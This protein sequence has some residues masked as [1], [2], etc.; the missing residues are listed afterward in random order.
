MKEILGIFKRDIRKILKSKM[1][2]VILVGMMII[3]GIYAWLN[4]DSN[5]DPYDNTGN[6]EI[7]VV[8]KDEGAEILSSKVN[9][10]E[11]L[12][13]NLKNNDAMKWVFTDEETAKNGVES[14]EYYGAIILPND[15]SGRLTTLLDETEIKKLEF[16]FLVN[17]KKNPIAPIIVNKAVGAVETTLDQAF[18]NK[19]VYNV[20]DKAEDLK[21]DERGTKTINAVTTKLAETKENIGKLKTTINVVADSANATAKAFSAVKDLLPSVKQF[22]DTT[23]T[24]ITELQSDI[25][26]LD[27]VFDEVNDDISNTF[28]VSER[29]S[30]NIRNRL[31]SLSG[32]GLDAQQKLADLDSSLEN[33][34]TI[35]DQQQRIVAALK[36]ITSF[37]ELDKL[38]N[39]I[40]IAK[41]KV[42]VLR[43]DIQGVMD[44]T[45]LIE[46]AKADANELA[47]S[48]AS[49]ASHY[50]DSI[51][52][53]VKNSFSRLNSS[54]KSFVGTFS[55]LSGAFSQ[56]EIALSST[57]DALNSASGFSANV[58]EMLSNLQ[59][60]IDKISAVLSGV[61]KSD[62]YL[63]LTNLLKNSPEDVADFI[64]APISTREVDYYPIEHYGSK[65]SPF[66]TILATWVG[67]TLLVAVLKT[68][69]EDDEKRKNTK[70]YQAFFGRFMLFGVIAVMQGLVIG[71]G[72]III[73]VQII[74]H[75]LF[76]LTIML[77]SLVY[78]MIVYSLAISFGKIG[79]ALAVVMM[80][81]QVAGSGGTFPIEL[82]PDFFQRVQPMMPFYP[83]MS[84]LRETIGGFYGNSYIIFIVL[85]LCHL[86]IPLFLGLV[87]RRPII[88]IKNKLA[89]EVEETDVIV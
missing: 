39:M 7:A 29:I 12:V 30:T 53:I 80:V 44:G 3:P 28:K 37:D 74:N 38:D 56:S 69:I 77:S 70:L 83:S 8:N 31:N 47:N 71:I 17:Q 24:N 4:I 21:L 81:L 15:F 57:I 84:A 14:G 73:G 42:S 27:Q 52:P 68:D 33:L 72:D 75:P 25:V 59:N 16:D 10:G 22:T 87:I 5:W 32:A 19:I 13:E 60:D 64:S 66:Y 62:L 63:K 36:Q 46:Q 45:V 41:Q 50:A 34:L 48:L 26:S 85:L 89:K 65:M 51:A 67:C 9:I 88:K 1:A 61:G 6:L 2:V 23:N 40:S 82:L 11:E 49:I 20:V 79:E 78:M 55:S 58:N 43:R 18:V 54:L 86:I 76:L 35:L